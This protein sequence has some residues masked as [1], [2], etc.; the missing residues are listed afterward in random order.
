MSY[1][2]L[3]PLFYIP[4]RIQNLPDREWKSTFLAI[5]NSTESRVR[6]EFSY[7]VA[8]NR[9]WIRGRISSVNVDRKCNICNEVNSIE[10]VEHLFIHCDWVQKL[11]EGIRIK[12]TNKTFNAEEIIFHNGLKNRDEQNV[13]TI[14]KRAIWLT[15][16]KR[17]KGLYNVK[18]EFVTQLTR[19]FNSIL[20]RE[21]KLEKARRVPND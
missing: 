10:T 5:H 17:I 14:Y 4:S 16:Q 7:M 6:R 15:R 11:R 2:K 8:I 12:L 18:R 13:T 1:Q 21:S 20:I 9:I 19:C 3:L